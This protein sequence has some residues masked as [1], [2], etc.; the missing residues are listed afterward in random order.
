MT[1]FGKYITEYPDQTF[2]YYWRARSNTARDSA[3]EKG[4]AVPHYQNLIAVAQKD[5]VVSETN[6][7]WMIEAYGYLAAYETNT[8]KNYAVAIQYFE[9]LL[10]LDPQNTDAQ[11]YIGILRK[12]LS[13]PDAENTETTKAGK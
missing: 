4:Y 11:K 5:T 3:M 6:K 10:E 1:V 2:G 9:K 8:N 12:N 13:S 7:K